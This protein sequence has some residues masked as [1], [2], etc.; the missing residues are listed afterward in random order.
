[1]VPADLHMQ[2]GDR[3]PADCLSLQPANLGD[4]VPIEVALVEI[5]RSLL[6]LEFDL[7]QVA[8]REI[9]DRDCV[10][11]LGEGHCRVLTGGHLT[12]NLFRSIPRLVWRQRTIFAD[13]VKSVRPG[14]AGPLGTVAHE[15]GL[16]PGMANT[17]AEAG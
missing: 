14:A 9:G 8:G 5:G 2:L 17:K 7:L 10:A 6:A 12:K 4:N 16:S 15:K 3:R 1:M 11:R 13:G